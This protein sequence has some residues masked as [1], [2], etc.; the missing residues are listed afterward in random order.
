MSVSGIGLQETSLQNTDVIGQRM[1]GGS[2][3]VSFATGRNSPIVFKVV[4]ERSES[5]G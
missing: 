5:W 4:D 3:S 2:G 1:G